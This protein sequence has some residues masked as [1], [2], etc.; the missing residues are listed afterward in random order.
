MHVKGKWKDIVNILKE[1]V[2]HTHTTVNLEFLSQWKIFSEIKKNKD[3]GSKQKPRKC[4]PVDMHD[5]IIRESSLDG[6]K[7]THRNLNIHKE[8]NWV[9]NG[10][11]VGKH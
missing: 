7:I 1:N 3:L 6:K 4:I 11:H 2:I 8:I 5:K 9:R 10:K